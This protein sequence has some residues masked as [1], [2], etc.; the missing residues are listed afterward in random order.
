MGNWGLD[1]SDNLESIVNQFPPKLKQ[2]MFAAASRGSLRRGTWNHCAFNAAGFEVGKLGEVRSLQ[3]A[4]EA[5]DVTPILVKKFIRYWDHMTG[6]KE[7]VTIQLREAIEKVGLFTKS[8][9]SRIV[10]IKAFEQD[11]K[12][13]REEFDQ[14]MELNQIPDEDM[15]SSILD[16][17][18]AGV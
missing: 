14:L 11:E 12:A 2:A 5:F 6:T 8:G 4:A 7:E 13:K 10:W 1:V 17:S 15:A 3:S 16:G 9:A 18:L